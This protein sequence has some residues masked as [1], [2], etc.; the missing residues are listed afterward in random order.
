VGALCALLDDPQV[1]DELI[2]L[3]FRLPRE[4]VQ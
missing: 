3:G 2:A 4:P 1:R